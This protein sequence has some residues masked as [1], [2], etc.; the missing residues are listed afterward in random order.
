M[1]RSLVHPSVPSSVASSLGAKSLRYL[2]L[3]DH[4]MTETLPC[5]PASRLSK[6]LTFW[7]DSEALLFDL[8]EIADIGGVSQVDLVYD[9]REHGVKSLLQPNLG[10]HVFCVKMFPTSFS[11][12]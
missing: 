10:R 1:T 12:S 8:L 7:G 5:V 11:L 2:S 9:K 3:V 6:L 4:E